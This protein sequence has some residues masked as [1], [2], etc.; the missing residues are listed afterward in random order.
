MHPCPRLYGINITSAGAL[1]R[2]F[3][4]AH[5]A[6]LPRAHPELSQSSCRPS[7]SPG[8][9]KATL[10]RA[11]PELRRALHQ[12]SKEHFAEA[13]VSPFTMPA[14]KRERSSRAGSSVT[15]YNACTQKQASAIILR[16]LKC[17]RLLFMPVHNP[18][19]IHPCNPPPPKNNN[20]NNQQ[21][22]TKE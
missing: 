9:H 12:R 11:H 20:N 6:T 19:G 22:K 4:R 7:E 10:R 17:R 3:S 1:A 21:H 15:V 5:K 14:H 2:S 8:P 18:S 13:Q 16:W